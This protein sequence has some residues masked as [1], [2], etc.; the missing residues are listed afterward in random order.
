MEIGIIK[1]TIKIANKYKIFILLD[2]VKNQKN[3]DY[4]KSSL[5]IK[6]L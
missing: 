6:I 1:T 3:R 2:T 4:Q 5:K